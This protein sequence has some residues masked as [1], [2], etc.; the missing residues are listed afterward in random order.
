[1]KKLVVSLSLLGILLIPTVTFAATLTPVQIVAI[2]R[3]VGVSEQVISIIQIALNQPTGPAT[4]PIPSDS[5][6]QIRDFGAVGVSLSLPIDYPGAVRKTGARLL[7]ET[8]TSP[9]L[10]TALSSDDYNNCSISA[11]G[12]SDPNYPRRLLILAPIHYCLV[13]QNDGAAGTGEMSYKYIAKLQDGRYLTIRFNVLYPLQG[14]GGQSSTQILTQV[15]SLFDQITAT[16]RVTGGASNIGSLSNVTIL[17][18]LN[19]N[20]VTQNTNLNISWSTTEKNTIERV[21]V[22]VCVAN[23]TFAAGNSNDKCFMAYPNLVNNGRADSVFVWTNVPAGASAYIKVRKAG[24]DSVYARSAIFVVVPQPI[25]GVSIKV[26]SPNGG[27]VY[28]QNQQVP[29]NVKISGIKGS[30]TVHYYLQ[31]RYGARV[32]DW[33]SEGVLVSN[34]VAS[35][36]RGINLFST[37]PGFY[38]VQAKW[39]GSGGQTI[40]DE[41]DGLFEVRSSSQNSTSF[42]SVATDKNSYNIGEVVRITWLS[43]T[44]FSGANVDLLDANGAFIAGI[45][46][47][48]GGNSPAS[49]TIPSNIKAGSYR[50][51]VGQVHYN[52]A[53]SP[54][55]QVTASNVQPTLTL[56]YP[57]GGEI[58]APNKSQTIRWSYA[59]SDPNVSLELFLAHNNHPLCYLGNS[60][61]NGGSFTFNPTNFR[62]SGSDQVVVPDSGYRIIMRSYYGN[63]SIISGGSKN[64]FTI[65][66][67]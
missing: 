25:S 30:G 4:T 5:V 42:S 39:V 40:Y 47:T 10:S 49:W 54:F 41:T 2:L 64:T 57:N 35:P 33:G 59:G 50:I 56:N 16:L 53:Y 18:G 45:A 27:E 44:G 29:I 21:D 11:T 23:Q 67:Q 13:T 19:N 28:T 36:S 6:W 20:Q 3:A 9:I 62:C 51:R 66:A 24:D 31:D 60:T 15:R 7:D 46:N 43:P 58:W 52:D 12:A 65:S 37:K 1:M 48:S 8:I 14:A 17:S 61:N 22:L 32:Y 34:G 63:G 38:K 26:V 55:F